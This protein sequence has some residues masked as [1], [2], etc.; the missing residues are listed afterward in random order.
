MWM[1]KF[2]KLDFTLVL[3]FLSAMFIL[4]SHNIVPFPHQSTQNHMPVLKIFNTYTPQYA[5]LASST[6]QRYGFQYLIVLVL[7]L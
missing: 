7:R 1:W 2:V 5:F 4:L 3:I 6:I